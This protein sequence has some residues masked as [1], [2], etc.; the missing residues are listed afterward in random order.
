[1]SRAVVEQYLQA[2]GIVFRT[3][4]HPPVYTCDEL[5]PHLSESKAL[6]CKNLLVRSNKTR[7]CLLVIVPCSRRADLKKIGELTGE[8][9]LSFAGPETLLD[10][11]GVDAGSVGPFGLINNTERDV[12]VLLDSEV[13]EAETVAFHPND[14]T[15]SVLLSREMFRGYLAS[16]ANAVR[17]LEIT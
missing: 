3:L 12:A 1:V 4:S 10:K 8:G 5:L 7:R 17:E 14:N 15:S 2:R 11:L 6:G 16:L 9:K 13:A